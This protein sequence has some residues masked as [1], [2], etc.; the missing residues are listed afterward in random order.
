MKWGKPDPVATFRVYPQHPSRLSAEVSVYRNL[1]DM[2]AGVRA[3]DRL[4][5]SGNYP[6]VSSR[7]L[8]GHC[9]GCTERAL[10][11]HRIAT[12]IFAYVYL[13]K[14]ELGL[15]VIVHEATH[16]ALRWLQ[17]K[18]IEK[19]HTGLLGYSDENEE[20]FAYAVDCMSRQIVSEC[21]KRGLLEK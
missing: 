4:P 14:T 9:V 10:K 17:R 5:S 20:A 11:T 16:A 7:K 8:I 2:R 13:A 12:P 19:L 18:E 21:R 15:G 6:A 3:L 1:A